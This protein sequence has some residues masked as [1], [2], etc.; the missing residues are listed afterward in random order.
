MAF[1]ALLICRQQHKSAQSTKHR[2]LHLAASLHCT[3][4]A[5][6]LGIV[7]LDLLFALRLFL[8]DVG[9]SLIVE[10]ELIVTTLRVLQ[11]TIPNLQA[12]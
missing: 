8:H 9:F 5:L 1:C 6:G 2:A 12:A 7:L 10:Q 3:H 11:L 4:L